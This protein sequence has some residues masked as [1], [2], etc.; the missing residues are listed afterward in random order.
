MESCLNA[1][2]CAIVTADAHAR[3]DENV[4]QLLANKPILA[5][6][7]KY[8]VEEYRKKDN[9]GGK[10]VNP[11]SDLHRMLSTLLS[12][13]LEPKKKLAALQDHFGI[14]VTNKMEA[15]VERM[16]NYSA[17]IEEKGI[18]KGI[19]QGISEGRAQGI[20]EGRAQ[21]ISEGV[22]DNRKETALR[23]IQKGVLSDAEIAEYTGM[24]ETEVKQLRESKMASL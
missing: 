9:E 19:A 6:I 1:L 10:A 21:G 16:C 7:L 17:M 22:A 3:L 13:D 18:A 5:W 14:P 23:M 8:G 11:G 2:G 24:T 4:K 12:G 15:E 20:S